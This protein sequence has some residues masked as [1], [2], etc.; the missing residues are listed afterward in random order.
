MG[1][2][3]DNF[4]VESASPDT[5]EKEE[6]TVSTKEQREIDKAKIK[7][8]EEDTLVMNKRNVIIKINEYKSALHK[9]DDSKLDA[10]AK[11]F[12]TILSCLGDE[13]EQLLKINMAAIKSDIAKNGVNA[14]NSA[15][16]KNCEAKLGIIEYKSF[17]KEAAER[18]MRS[19]NVRT[20][21]QNPGNTGN[22]NKSNRIL[23]GGVLGVA[24]AITLA[25]GISSCNKKNKVADNTTTTNTITS[26]ME[27]TS[28]MEVTVSTGDYTIET[29]D[30]D[31]TAPTIATTESTNGTTNK[32][33]KTNGN[34]GNNG[35]KDIDATT[36]QLRPTTNPKKKKVIKQA[37]NKKTDKTKKKTYP[38]G[39]D[40]KVINGTKPEVAPTGNDKQTLPGGIEPTHIT[41]NRKGMVL[42]YTRK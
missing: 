42:Q 29:V 1:F 31:Y 38:T 9:H 33:G 28:T 14:L 20:N 11:D 34:G 40:G 8:L 13:S 22:K 37:Q 30:P 19:E 27:E 21:N 32:D 10:I 23:V 5:A 25:A 12:R 35:S 41:V 36:K 2:F 17:M 26:T 24:T 15:K 7:K 16:S 6:N 39:K 4:I 18:P 3:E